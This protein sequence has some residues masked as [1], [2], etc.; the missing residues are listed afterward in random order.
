MEPSVC[1]RRRS[2]AAAIA[3]PFSHR[4]NTLGWQVSLPL[5]PIGS[6]EKVNQRLLVAALHAV[7]DCLEFV[8][9]MSRGCPAH[10]HR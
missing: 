7:I 10:G 6:A 2:G 1:H 9:K 5:D 3:V 4:E 8:M